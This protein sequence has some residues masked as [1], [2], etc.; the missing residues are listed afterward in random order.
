MSECKRNYGIDVIKILAMCMVLVL[1]IT[2]QGGIIKSCYGVSKLV[3]KSIQMSAL[4]AVNIL[5]I[6][7]G[8]LMYGKKWSKER[9]YT[10]CKQVII[11]NLLVFCIALCLDVSLK[12]CVLLTFDAL[13]NTYWYI[14]DY[15][16]L[17]LIMPFIDK[18]IS[19]T[20][21]KQLSKLVGLC[22]II[23]TILPCILLKDLFSFNGGYSL[24]WMMYLYCV[25]SYFRRVPQNT[26]YKKFCLL[27]LIVSYASMM[28]IQF[29]FRTIESEV[30]KNIV[31]SSM[32]YT[33][34][35]VFG[36]SVCLFLLSL[37]I[38]V[39]SK[40]Q[41]IVV[42]YSDATLIT[43]VLHCNGIFYNLFL[44]DAFS[45]WGQFSITFILIRIFV[46]ILIYYT[47]SVVVYSLIRTCIKNNAKKDLKLTQ[48]N[49]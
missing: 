27:G 31:S 41:K 19:Q 29:I 42:L 22:G 18:A 37:D 13:G 39:N 5:C 24:I 46:T 15:L 32:S 11:V 36:M 35:F 28:I 44:R 6:C 40:L 33:S 4:P 47:F 7:T 23:F 12:D 49:H 34:P 16:C 48:G 38:K 3:I 2:S 9:V 10:V 45:Y 25:G 30:A 1:H 21:T 20:E 8:Y 14:V 43:Y 26:K 17:L